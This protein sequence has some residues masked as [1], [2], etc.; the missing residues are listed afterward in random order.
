MQFQSREKMEMLIGFLG[1][2]IG[3]FLQFIYAY[4]AEKRLLKNDYK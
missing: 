2:I 1:V 4:R 3:A